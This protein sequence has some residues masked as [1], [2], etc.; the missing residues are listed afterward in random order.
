M[1]YEKDFFS[2]TL[3]QGCH[4][5]LISSFV[6]QQYKYNVNLSLTSNNKLVSQ[7]RLKA[8]VQV[9]TPNKQVGNIIRKSSFKWA[10]YSTIYHLQYSRIQLFAIYSIQE[11]NYLPFTVF[12]NSTIY[13]QQY[14][15]IQLFTIYS[16][17]EFNCLLFT[18]FKNSTIYHL[19]Y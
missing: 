16:I 18:V 7:R 3:N 10:Q 17:Q 15:R 12:K 19:Q 13:H 11:F 8:R 2:Q 4:Y 6:I 1:S 9:M 5:I 14:S